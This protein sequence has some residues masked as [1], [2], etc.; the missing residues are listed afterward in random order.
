V[1]ISAGNPATSDASRTV[2]PILLY[3][4]ISNAPSTYIR[5]FAVTVE[6]F[7]NQLDLIVD[8][9]RTP[10][11]V[12]TLVDGLRGRA[13]LPERPIV[14][15]F[16]DG[17]FNFSEVA[18]DALRERGLSATLYVTTGFLSGRPDIAAARPFDDRM[19]SWSQ[20]AEIA[21]GGVEIGAHSH[22][23]PHLDTLSRQ[24]AWREIAD[25]K[26]LLEAELGTTVLSFAY[27]HGYSSPGVRRLVLEAGYQSACGVK[28]AL[29]STD[30]NP[31]A[32]AR[33]TI[34]ANTSLEQF[35]AWVHGR[36]ARTASPRESPATRI[37]RLHR[38]VSAFLRP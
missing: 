17:F 21:S 26:R 25:C 31:F 7:R 34:Q 9:G 4:S 35:T 23:H 19:L 38:R 28:N 10:L 2:I 5:P 11:T 24:K 27:P 33:L 8:S 36:G 1:S 14:I 20:L 32:L 37:W 15:T 29:S 12:S 30:D 16:D 3:H 6:A 22:S 13:R 18:V